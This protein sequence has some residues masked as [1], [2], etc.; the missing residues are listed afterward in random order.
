MGSSLITMTFSTAFFD[1]TVSGPELNA[2]YHS[3]PVILQTTL[4]QVLSF[5]HISDK[6]SGAWRG[7]KGFAQDHR[8]VGG[9]AVVCPGSLTL[10]SV[11]LT[12]KIL[13]KPQRGAR[14][15]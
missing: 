7:G 15:R 4:R 10:E 11:L 5:F 12:T 2:S 8:A 9:G 14:M 1:P 13:P 3:S 6:V